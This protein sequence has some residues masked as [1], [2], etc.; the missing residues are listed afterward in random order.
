MWFI[1]VC[2]L[3]AP[4]AGF[5]TS[6]W[7]ES[8]LIPD[9]AP[10]GAV[11]SIAGKRFGQFRSAHENRV[12]FRGTPA[13]IQRWDPDLIVV[14]VPLRAT[15]GPV[16]VVRGKKKMTVGTFTVQKPTVQ[17][18]VPTEV[19]PGTLLQITGANFT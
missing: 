9:A 3:L 10:P 15:N 2:I 17:A 18:V 19:E 7:A 5:T 1:F 16:E 4:L 11:V 13:L 6:A 12:L 8:S 14:K